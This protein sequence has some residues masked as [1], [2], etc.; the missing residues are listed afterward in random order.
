MMKLLLWLLLSST[1]V[2]SAWIPTTTTSYRRTR[3]LQ[4]QEETTTSS[5]GWSVADDWNNLSGENPY[6]TAPDTDDIF[7]QD[8]AQNAA[9]SILADNDGEDLPPL[10]KEDVWMQEII[11]EIVTDPLSSTPL[12]D[13]LGR[14]RPSKHKTPQQQHQEM[15][16]HM[17]DEIAMLIRCNESP[18]DMLVRSGKAVADLTVEQKLD[19]SQLLVWKEDEGSWQATPFLSKA[20]HQIFQTH[21]THNEKDDLLVMDAKGVAQW[22]TKSIGE[23]LGTYTERVKKGQRMTSARQKK[24]FK[25]TKHDSRVLRLITQYSTYGTGYLTLENLECT[26]MDALTRTPQNSGKAQ[27]ESLEVLQLRNFEH[28]RQVWRDLG[29]HGIVSPTEQKWKQERQ[30]LQDKHGTTQELVSKIG[31]TDF[32]DECEVLEYGAYEPPPT[33]QQLESGHDAKN[34]KYIKDSSHTKVQLAADGK[35][36]LYMDE[37]QFVF[38]DEESCIGCM[39]CIN[40]APSSFLMLEDGRARAFKQRI[41]GDVKQGVMSCPVSCMHHVSYDELKELE[42]VRD[43]GD[44]RDDHGHM[45]HKRGH[46]P[47]HVARRSSDNNHRSS[48]YHHIK[49]KCC[50]SGQC[51]QRGCFDCPSYT[52]AGGNPYFQK[53]AKEGQHVRANHFIN[54]GDVDLWRKS[55]DL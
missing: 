39:Q 51:P 24:S 55:A 19:V 10:S 8:I 7:N 6:N 14:D 16:Q 27:S 35:T 43:K 2:S 52:Q 13:T 50:T 41:G 53:K 29:N 15:E 34:H 20:I 4:A 37:G 36:P 5:D 3:S 40:E 1:A 49:N 47:L 38:I 28:I 33:A 9:L 44:G 46:T 54:N 22:M 32:V 26:Y 45:G 23:E 21:A 31:A 30:S 12:Y 48:W 25:L 42:T 11:G 17:E 18:E